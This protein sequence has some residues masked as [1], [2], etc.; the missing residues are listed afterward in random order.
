[1]IAHQRLIANDGKEVLLFPL[2]Y[3][4]ISQDEGGSYS[5][6]GT[7]NI[8]FLGW[9]SNGREYN[10]PYYA[11]CKCKLVYQ[12]TT[13]A[14]NIWESVNEVHTPLGLMK[15]CF[16][17]VH[18]DNL[19]YSVGTILDQGDTLGYTGQSGYATGDHLHLN[20]ASGTYQGQEQVQPSGNWQLINSEHIYEMMYVNGTIIING[21]GHPWLEYSGGHSSNYFKSKFPWVLYARKLR[22]RV[23]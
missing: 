23:K 20:V 6:D 5:H 18:D 4:N 1:M 13:S 3:M 11:P 19:P 7:Y 16:M 12:N 2:T 15:V 9:N 21:E 17:V 22:K 14:T 8:D 10:C